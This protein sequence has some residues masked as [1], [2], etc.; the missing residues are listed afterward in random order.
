M[1]VAAGR[2]DHAGARIET[3]RT[4]ARGFFQCTGLREGQHRVV[5]NPPALSPLAI[6]DVLVHPGESLV[7]PKPAR[8]WPFGE[9]E[10]LFDPPLDRHGKPWR[11]ELTEASSLYPSREGKSVARTASETGR[12]IANGLRADL[13]GVEI[14]DSAGA[15]ME[16][17]TIDLFG[18]GRHTLALSIRPILVRGTVRAGDRPLKA[19]LELS[20]SHGGFLKTASD[21]LGHF[22]TSLPSAGEWRVTVLYP[23]QSAAARITAPPLRIPDPPPASPYDVTIQLAGGRIHGKVTGSKGESSSAAVHAR[24]SRTTAHQLT[25]DDG[26]FDIVGLAA[27]T[28]QL[29]A[30][31]IAGMTAEPVEVHIED[32]ESREVNLVTEPTVLLSGN[33]VTPDGRPA[34]G[35]VVRLSS[36]SEPRWATRVTDVHGHFEYRGSRAMTRVQAV[37]V[38]YDYPI[39][40][41]SIAVGEGETN[42]QRIQLHG[43][44][45]RLRV[46]SSGETYISGRGIVAPLGILSYSQYRTTD[47]GAY[48]ESGSYTVCQRRGSAGS[49][50]DVTV[51]PGSETNLDLAAGERGRS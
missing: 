14:H 6:S 48:I 22:E 24:G 44:G 30:E 38:T 7:L 40:F 5:I 18:G 12:L 31:N 17:T 43:D 33:V 20:D 51:T 32:D 16:R 39:S 2:R 29:G 15:L 3:V 47:A 41:V 26:A 50:R 49:C 9:A 23:P 27:G 8:P 13:Y 25:G 45:G 10:M 28:Y 1:E 35:A 37:V 36:N 34:S 46:L 19:N 4:N 21:D 11:V 42:D